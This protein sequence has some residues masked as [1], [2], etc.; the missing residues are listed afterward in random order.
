MARNLLAT[1]F[2]ANTTPCSLPNRP[3]AANRL[4][5]SMAQGA[6]TAE[7]EDEEEEVAGAS[8]LLPPPLQILPL[9]L[10][11]LS[12]L[13]VLTPG[14]AQYSVAP[15]PS[16]LLDPL[17]DKVSTLLNSR[18]IVL[19]NKVDDD[20]DDDDDDDE[21]DDEEDDD[22]DEEDATEISLRGNKN[23]HKPCASHKLL[24]KAENSSAVTSVPISTSISVRRTR[25]MDKRSNVPAMVS[26]CNDGCLTP[27]P[28]GPD[29]GC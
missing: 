2:A 25:G 13:T 12:W 11:L 10:L 5:S 6:S 26:F 28:C 17:D 16:F 4:D 7:E 24:S 27:V 23:I 18:D 1:S 22:D 29:N 19:V 15:L 3:S 20:D 14:A 21:E 9:R 8:K